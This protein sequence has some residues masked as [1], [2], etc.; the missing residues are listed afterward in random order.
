MLISPINN[1][2]SVK[3]TANFKGLWGETHYDDRSES[4]YFIHDKTYEYYPFSDEKKEEIE[5]VKN[6]NSAYR[7]DIPGKGLVANPWVHL[8]S[9]FV[10]V[11]PVLPFTS[12]EFMNYT[13]NRLSD[14]KR[15]IIENL[16]NDK[17]LTIMKKH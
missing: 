11:M 1:S 6:K 2:M 7:E 9:V 17:K 16:I 8:D 4:E 13:L 3:H 14:A 5:A 10:K 15:N 12:K